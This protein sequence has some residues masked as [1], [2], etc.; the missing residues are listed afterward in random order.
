[1]TCRNG[2]ESAFHFEGV[3]ASGHRPHWQP[4]SCKIKDFLQILLGILLK[5]QGMRSKALESAKEAHRQ[6]PE[7]R[8]E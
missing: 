6:W 2:C 4:G 7:G 5:I 3:Q 1:M 8:S